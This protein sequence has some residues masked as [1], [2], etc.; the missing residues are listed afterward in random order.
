MDYALPPHESEPVTTISWRLAHLIVGIFG[1]RNASHFGGPPVDYQTFEYASSAAAAL[2]QLD[3]GYAAWVKGVRSL[4]AAAL[5]PPCGPAEAPF[6]DVSMAG[7]V[8]HI[9]REVIHH[10]AEVSLLR[11]LWVQKGARNGI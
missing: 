3:D 8:L 1:L 10:G 2:R 9:N 11:D 4:D 5:A 6:G 7:L